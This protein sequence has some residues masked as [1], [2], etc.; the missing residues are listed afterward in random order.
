MKKKTKKSTLKVSP[1]NRM[2]DERV[3]EFL[4]D[5][6]RP[7]VEITDT[8]RPLWI[9]LAV[10]H[11]K[12]E[13]GDISLKANDIMAT[14]T[15]NTKTKKVE[16]R[17]RIRYGNG[18]KSVFDGSKKLE[19]RDGAYSPER[20]RAMQENVREMY[21]G[22]SAFAILQKPHELDFSLLDT[23]DVIAQAM[24]DSNLFDIGRVPAGKKK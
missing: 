1:G 21:Q 22:T 20:V 5:H 8:V 15:Y 4:K 18:T 14:V 10:F 11:A 17:G 16:T 23:S 3:N 6:T 2:S 12:P 24:Q 9:F 7:V 13:F 19:A